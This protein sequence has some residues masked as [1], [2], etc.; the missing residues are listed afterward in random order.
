MP[1]LRTDQRMRHFILFFS[2]L[3]NPAWALDVNQA[4]EAELD[5]LRGL[6]PAF[7]RRL[8]RER[9]IRN[10]TDWSDLM[11]RVSGMGRA[12]AEKLSAQGLTVQGMAWESEKKSSKLT[13]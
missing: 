1:V 8:M 2:L 3:A 11:R 4:T 13:P 9:D 6:G 7:T 12:T 5:G 10:F